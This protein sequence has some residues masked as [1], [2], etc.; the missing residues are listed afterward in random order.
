MPHIMVVED[1]PTVRQL[2]AIT[3]KRVPNSQISEATNGVDALNKLSS[4]KF[5]L[6]LADI[7]M[8]V[9]D[10]LKFIGAVKNDPKYKDIPVIII[11]T[12]G[13]EADRKKGM[14]LGASAYLSKPIQSHEL[15]NVVKKLL[16]E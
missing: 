12:E 5:D 6:I 3:L 15:L 11:T 2:I 9:M 4:E 13:A 16:G 8:P 1:S 10:G 14:A 7:N